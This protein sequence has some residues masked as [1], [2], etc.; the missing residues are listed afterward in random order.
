MKPT[1]RMNDRNLISLMTFLL[2]GL[3]ISAQ[4][5]D[6]LELH[7]VDSNYLEDQFYVGLGYNALRDKPDLFSQRNL[8]F[9]LQLGFIK[10]IPLNA[11]RNVGLGIGMGYAVNSYYSNMIATQGGSG[12]TYALVE[13]SEFRRSKLETHSLEFPLELR[14]R[15]SNAT[16]YRFWRIYGGAKLG[17]V[18]SGRSRLVLE[19]DR[20][21]FS[22]GDIDPLQ[23]G[24]ILNVGY[25]TWNLHF[26]Y[27][28]NPLLEEGAQLDSGESLDLKVL[29]IGVIFYIL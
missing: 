20:Q 6:S 15:T 23:Y 26:Y 25:H 10:D 12:T 17:Y 24:L 13:E 29:R 14:W 3:G 21:G 2:L 7:K 27:G 9:N 8:S 1:P 5:V 11:A 18:F 16:D 22:N 28:L 4:K 19:G